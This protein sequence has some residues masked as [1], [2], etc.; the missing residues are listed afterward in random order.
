MNTSDR[1]LM[2]DNIQTKPKYRFVKIDRTCCNEVPLFSNHLDEPSSKR[3]VSRLD[4]FKRRHEERA[5][6]REE[7]TEDV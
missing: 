2:E 4:Q 7:E 1:T 5:K 6:R 3:Y